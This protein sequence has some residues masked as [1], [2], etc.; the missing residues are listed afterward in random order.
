ML[1]TI[2][3]ALA[4]GIGLAMEYHLPGEQVAVALVAVVIVSALGGG[5]TSV[6]IRAVLAIGAL[7]MLVK[8]SGAGSDT[9]FIIAKLTEIVCLLAGIWIMVR[10]VG[11]AVKRFFS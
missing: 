9:R 3:S 8:R 5:R 11:L 6:L 1:W 7:S 4:F 2:I 10:G